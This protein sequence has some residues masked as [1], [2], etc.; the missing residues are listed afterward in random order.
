MVEQERPGSPLGD[1]RF[2]VVTIEAPVELTAASPQGSGEIDIAGER[3]HYRL[4]GSAGQTITLEASIP[5]IS[6]LAGRIYLYTLRTD[7][8][9]TQRGS[10]VLDAPL[11]A[12]SSVKA[13]LT[14]PA[15]GEYIIQVDGVGTLGGST[16]GYTVGV[17]F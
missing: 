11:S 9:W 7:G 15:D 2:Q 12:S 3:D 10:L 1:Y 6:S 17:Q 13:S 8:N 4:T 16:G 14:L 5:S